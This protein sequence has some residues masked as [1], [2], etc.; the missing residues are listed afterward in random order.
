MKIVII[1]LKKKRFRLVWRRQGW[2]NQL[3]RESCTSIL[4]TNV[5]WKFLFYISVVLVEKQ[6]FCW[7]FLS[8]RKL[9]GF[10]RSYKGKPC[11][12]RF[13]FPSCKATYKDTFGTNQDI[14][15]VLADQSSH[16][17]S[18]LCLSLPFSFTTATYVYV[19]VQIIYEWYSINV[20]L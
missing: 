7:I 6:I 17:N 8:N 11:W 9:F 13:P 16:S 1:Y 15:G 4:V 3:V 12:L 18:R 5:P 10:N 14:A 20:Y 19:L 2:K